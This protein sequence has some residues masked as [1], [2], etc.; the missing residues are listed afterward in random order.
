MKV[1]ITFGQIHVHSV[2]GRTYDKDCIAEIHCVSREEG[3]ELAMLYF[4]SK[5]AFE[6]G[7]EIVKDTSFL[8]FFP[9][10]IITVN[11]ED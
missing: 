5:W 10:G 7:E 9:R 4:G 6:Y 11:Y 1:Y 2:N 3:R 8:S